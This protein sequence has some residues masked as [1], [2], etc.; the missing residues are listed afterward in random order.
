MSTHSVLEDARRKL[1][2]LR[3]LDSTVDFSRSAIQ[4][5]IVFTLWEFKS[6]SINDISRSL[7]I[8]KRSALD[9]LRKLQI[10]GLVG[11]ASENVDVFHLTSIGE[12]YVKN[13][14]TLLTGEVR[15]PHIPLSIKDLERIKLPVLEVLVSEYVHHAII[16]LG[17][18]RNNELPLQA[19]AKAIG[20]SPPRLQSYLDM[21]TETQDPELK[22]FHKIPRQTAISKLLSKLSI[23]YQKQKTH[24]KLTKKG[25]E[26]YRKLPSFIKMSDNIAMKLLKILTFSIHPRQV[27][28]RTG[29]MLSL[30][31]VIVMFMLSYPIG[32]IAGALWLFITIITGGMLILSF[33]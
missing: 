16:A 1:E 27:L 25:L 15:K 29:L 33:K 18:A 10:K 2:L 26:V 31:T 32:L 13:L 12:E 14:F 21:Y 24:Y 6:M 5:R 17:L 9:A 30:G 8:P 3:K 4:L 22:L 23:N 28:F 11:K 20:L 7:S 19:L